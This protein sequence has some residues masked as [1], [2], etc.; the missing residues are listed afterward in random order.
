MVS[1]LPVSDQ[2]SCSR[3]R[4]SLVSVLLQVGQEENILSVWTV[5]WHLT[6]QSIKLLKPAACSKSIHAEYN[7]R[8]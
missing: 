2:E 7:L 4:T 1:L 5:Y 6:Y 8:E 3:K